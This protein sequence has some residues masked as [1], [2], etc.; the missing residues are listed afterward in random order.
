M[1]TKIFK[2]KAY[3]LF[4]FVLG[5]DL[6]LDAFARHV[7]GPEPPGDQGV[8]HRHDEDREEVEHD[9]DERVV[10]GPGRIGVHLQLRG[11]QI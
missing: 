4:D 2:T 8:R 7:G 10:E 1:S 11:C 6:G 9:G 3:P 5:S